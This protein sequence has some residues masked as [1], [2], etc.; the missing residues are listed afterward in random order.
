MKKLSLQDKIFR[1]QARIHR[2]IQREAEA[3]LGGPSSEIIRYSRALD[4]DFSEI[5]KNLKSPKLRSSHIR[6]KFRVTQTELIQELRQSE[7]ILIGD[8]HPFGQSQR[9]ALR[10]LR[11]AHTQ[12]HPLRWLGLEL[13]SSKYQKVLDAFQRG[14]LSSTAFLKKIRYNE[15]WGF[16]WTHYAPLFTWARENQV[17]LLALNRPNELRPSHSWL[18]AAGLTNQGD[19][20][21]QRDQ[22]AAGIILD[23]VIANSTTPE[24]PVR[25][26]VLYGELHLA[27]RHLPAQIQSLSTTHLSRKIRVTTLHQN[28]EKTWW[29][30]ARRRLQHE[31]RLLHIRDSQWCLF[32]ASPWNRTQALLRFAEEG[33][34]RIDSHGSPNRWSEVTPLAFDEDLHADSD[35]EENRFD[36]LGQIAR[37]HEHLAQFFGLTPKE[38]SRL[39]LIELEEE[40]WFTSPE[41]K[42]RI[43]SADLRLMKKMV[44]WKLRFLDRRTQIAWIP[45]LTEN[46]LAET[47]AIALL[48]DRL[49][50]T[51]GATELEK[52][53][54]IP[55]FEYA[56]GFLGSLMIN[57][58]RKCELAGDHLQ[59]LSTLQ[60]RS[61]RRGVRETFTGERQAR[62]I[63]AQ[64]GSPQVRASQMALKM[65]QKVLNNSSRTLS[66]KTHLLRM[67]ARW[68]GRI[69]AAKA[70][71]GLT[72]NQLSLEQLKEV[73]EP[74]IHGVRA[75]FQKSREQNRVER[76][77]QF[78]RQLIPI[79]LPPTK[80]AWF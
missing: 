9:T 11:A 41:A 21:T 10:I 1:L 49:I 61:Q 66:E 38:L 53:F 37:W 48:D 73:F 8:Y 13:V 67:A 59:R 42:K 14:E 17:Q 15:E 6:K 74:E 16:P 80:S 55:L 50:S 36:A 46:A 75:T 20:L 27:S 57:P 51:Q 40:S 79:R 62:E 12:E 60:Y 35:A 69:L 25:G 29:D 52:L 54:L 71:E 47:A 34:T 45:E 3:L 33:N 58:R 70:H 68:S 77:I 44:Q 64:L 32:T 2:Q 28:H 24:T 26:A 39:T 5:R 56:F 63:A 30:L 22:W 72:L 65:A 76:L 18:N 23:H 19:D 31:T 7:V 4:H 78:H 43:Q